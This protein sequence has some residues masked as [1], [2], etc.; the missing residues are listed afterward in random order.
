MNKTVRHVITI[1]PILNKML[2]GI[3][4]VEEPQMEASKNWERTPKKKKIIYININEF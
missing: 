2:V 1:K 4:Q 3:V